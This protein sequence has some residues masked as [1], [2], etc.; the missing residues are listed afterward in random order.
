[1]DEEESV[2]GGLQSGNT[3]YVRKVSDLVWIISKRVF[4]RT[5]VEISIHLCT[6]SRKMLVLSSSTSGKHFFIP[7]R[8]F[9]SIILYLEMSLSVIILISILKSF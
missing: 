9:S 1:M 4:S 6:V 3:A 2:T 5:D 8:I 7:D